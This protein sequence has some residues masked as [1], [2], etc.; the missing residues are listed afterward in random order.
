MSLHCHLNYYYQSGTTVP[1]IR[2]LCLGHCFNIEYLQVLFQMNE[3][4]GKM[5]EEGMQLPGDENKE[6]WN[7]AWMAIK[8][9]R[10]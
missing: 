3:L 10:L 5:K 6:Q 4:K 2:P 9:V 7:R 1:G 8:K